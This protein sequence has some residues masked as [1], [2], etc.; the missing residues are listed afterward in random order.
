MPRS[1]GYRTVLHALRVPVDIAVERA[2]KRAATGARHA[3]VL[4][5][6]AV[7]HAASLIEEPTADE[8]V[9]LHE[10][11]DWDREDAGEA[12]TG[13]VSDPA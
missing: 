8:P 3:H 10:V 9:E 1:T 2:V 13:E 5:A 11:T 4:D 6:A 7:K 12:S